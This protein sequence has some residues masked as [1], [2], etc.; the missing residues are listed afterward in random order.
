VIERICQTLG[1]SSPEEVIRVLG[2]LDVNSIAVRGASKL[3][4]DIY[5]MFHGVF[6]IRI[7][8]GPTGSASG[9]VNLF[10]RSGSGAGSLLSTSKNLDKP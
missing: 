10:V 6:R 7:R 4:F 9:P 3:L 1:Y 8:F 2:Y 5:D